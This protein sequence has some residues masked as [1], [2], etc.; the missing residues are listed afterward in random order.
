MRQ[1][2][3]MWVL[4]LLLFSVTAAGANEPPDFFRRLNLE[5]GVHVAFLPG[6]ELA[7][8]GAFPL[9]AGYFVFDLP[10]G[11]DSFGTVN[12]RGIYE[13]GFAVAY[14]L[15]GATQQGAA[16]T[17]F[18][19]IRAGVDYFQVFTQPFNIAVFGGISF[20]RY[21][22]DGQGVTEDPDGEPEYIEVD[23]QYFGFSP[24]VGVHIPA[25]DWFSRLFV[26]YHVIPVD[27]DELNPSYVSIGGAVSLFGNLLTGR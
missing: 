9:S 26:T 16:I 21:S 3:T 25:L 12:V 1:K 8:G 2:C 19:S 18:S 5:L 10:T 11:E 24:R 27:D 13:P 17:L 7:S 20:G 23:G 4:T 22:V 14:N 15:D 6:F